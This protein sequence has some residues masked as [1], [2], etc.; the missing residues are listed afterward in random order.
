[1]SQ[2]DQVWARWLG[3]LL[4]YE[5]VESINS[6]RLTFAAPWARSAPILLI[7]GCI[8]LAVVAAAVYALRQP[9]AS[10][11]VRV[12]LAIARAALLGLILLI[13]AEPILELTQVSSPRPLLWQVF[14]GT[15][16]MN[17]QD[18]LSSADRKQLAESVGLDEETTAAENDAESK[19]SRMDY[20][21]AYLAKEEDNI[22]SRLDEKFRLRAFLFDHREGVRGLDMDLD[23]DSEFE[24]ESFVKTITSKG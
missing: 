18:E 24:P 13:L 6:A 19:P 20:L 5:N 9:R 17:I 8:L 12:P 3:S 11:M 2:L 1:M 7:L 15:D 23:S 10:W 14:D 16:S 4:G 22:L 21:K